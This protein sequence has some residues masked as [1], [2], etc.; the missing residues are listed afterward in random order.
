VAFRAFQLGTALSRLP[1]DERVIRTR[2]HSSHNV[3]SNGDRRK[4]Q[5]KECVFSFNFGKIFNNKI[6]N[7]MTEEI[8][9]LQSNLYNDV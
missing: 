3:E 5:D 8:N 7:N 9:F 2:A 1:A 6:Y 4:S